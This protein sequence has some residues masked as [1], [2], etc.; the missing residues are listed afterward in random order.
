MI[1][2]PVVAAVT[3]GCHSLRR[4]PARVRDPA[5]AR[6]P[7]RIAHQRGWRVKRPL[8]AIEGGAQCIR[9]NERAGVLRAR[10]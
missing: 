2:A 8:D 5:D 7:L 9:D 4:G 1:D 3:V 6:G 10:L